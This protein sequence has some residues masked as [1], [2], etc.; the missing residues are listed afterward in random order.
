[1]LVHTSAC[2]LCERPLLVLLEM[3]VLV[4]VLIVVGD[5]RIVL[6]SL[7]IGHWAIIYAQILMV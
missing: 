5:L 1:M 7:E 6:L 4:M 3:D 2:Q